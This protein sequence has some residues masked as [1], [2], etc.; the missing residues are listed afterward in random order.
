LLSNV[1][2]CNFKQKSVGQGNP[3]AK[4]LAQGIMQG[5]VLHDEGKFRT[6]EDI[7]Y[8]NA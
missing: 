1:E 2:Q 6:V 8:R 7:V 3:N 4:G 5:G